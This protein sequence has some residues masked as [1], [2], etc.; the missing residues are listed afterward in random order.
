MSRVGV[1]ITATLDSQV[2]VSI[3]VRVCVERQQL[4]ESCSQLAP[5]LDSSSATGDIKCKIAHSFKGH[6]YTCVHAHRCWGNYFENT[7]L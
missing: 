1:L 5:S 7:A 6:T 2:C 3:S 4:K